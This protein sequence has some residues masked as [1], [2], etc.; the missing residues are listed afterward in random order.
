MKQVLMNLRV[1]LQEKNLDL[2]QILILFLYLLKNLK[3]KH[4]FQILLLNIQ[5][6][7][8]QHRLL[9]HKV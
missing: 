5:K 7:N 2:N 1:A 8:F 3:V 4:I 6:R 9:D